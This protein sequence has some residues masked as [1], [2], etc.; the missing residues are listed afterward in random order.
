MEASKKG[1]TP[2]GMTPDW[3][4][5]ALLIFTATPIFF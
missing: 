5:L 1:M 3:K 4:M 2:K